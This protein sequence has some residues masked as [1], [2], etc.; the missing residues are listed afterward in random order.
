MQLTIPLSPK[1]GP[2]FRQVYLGLRG[3]ILAGRL[4]PGE[5]LPSTRELA[6][7][8]GISRTVALLAYNQLLAEGF[9]TGRSGSGTY[10]SDAI[11]ARIA[12]RPRTSAHVQLS[13]FGVSA[14]EASRTLHLPSRAERPLPLDFAVGCSDLESF[15][16]SVWR[17]LL[18]RASR[19]TRVAELDYGPASGTQALREAV[20][21]HLRRSRAV[22]CDPE[23]IIIVNGSQQALD[24]ITRVLIERGDRV[25][26]EDPS[27]QGTREV[28]RV[29]GARL[30][31][32]R[33]DRDGIDPER[34]PSRARLAFLT[35]SHQFPTGAVLPLARRLALLAWAKRANAVIVE[36]DYDGEFHY[37][38]QPVE[39]LQSLDREGR[40]LYIG[41]FSR[42]IF[43]ALRIGYLVVPEPL[44]AAFSAA[45]WLCDRHTATLEQQT[46]A[47]FIGEGHYERYLRKVRRRNASRRN[48]MLASI[49]ERMEGRVDVTGEGAGAHMVLWPHRRGREDHWVEAAAGSGICV[50]GIAPY[51]IKPPQ[52]GGLMLGYA[53]LS[54]PEIR[55]GIRRLAGIV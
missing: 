45:K 17:R 11:A 23:Q 15:P 34:L 12:P 20:A 53:R 24:L 19:K 1:Q 2:L 44:I 33:V 40:V 39:A 4:S 38:G 22:T 49:A 25:V 42:T 32:V 52:R 35:P 31:P 7:Q 6:E 55:E 46:L 54:E 3:A 36:D 26:I 5:K 41:T 29:A 13:R 51:Y 16:F 43:S 50:Y 47:A 28:L 48:M 30:C 27:Y 9:A 8:L 18:L 14:A 21:S 10:V 37:A